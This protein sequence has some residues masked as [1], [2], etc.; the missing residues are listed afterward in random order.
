VDLH[1]GHAIKAMVYGPRGDGLACL[2]GVRDLPEP[3]SGA[4]RWETL[5]ET[6]SDCFVLLTASAGENPRKILSRKGLS[7]LITDGE[8]E[9]TVDV[10]YG[11]G[12]KGKKNKK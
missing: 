8:I 11:G 3:G 12:K 1:L 2:L 4:Q 5:A 9:G 6:L 7:V 10:L